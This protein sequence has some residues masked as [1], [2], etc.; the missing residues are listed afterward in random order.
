MNTARVSRNIGAVHS[1]GAVSASR[2]LPVA[3][4]LRPGVKV[5][6][7]AAAGNPA[8]VAIYQEGVASGASFDDIAAAMSKV[9]GAPNYPLTPRNV[10]WFTARQGDFATPGAAAKILDLY[11][12]V[13]H[14]D[15]ERHIYT[16][17]II[18]PADDMDLVF[19]EQFEAWR[20]SELHRWSEADPETGVLQCMKRVE[21]TPDKSARRRWGGR[22]TEAERPCDPNDCALFGSGECKHIGSLSFWVPGVTGTSVIDLTFTSIYAS[23]GIAETLDMVRAGLG[24]ISGLHNGRPIFWLSK[25]REQVSQMNWETGKP[26][27]TDQWIIRLEASGLD[28]V[29]VLTGT[30]QQAALPAP[31]TAKVPALEEPEPPISADP[32]PEPIPQATT[33]TDPAIRELR[34]QLAALRDTLGWEDADLKE[35]VDGQGYDC[36]V[37]TR[38]AGCLVDMVAKLNLAIEAKSQREA[39]APAAEPA[40]ALALVADTEAP[41]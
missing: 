2:R 20:A 34:V 40:E 29:E 10:P 1:S 25:G 16:L 33:T 41:F 9:K 5:L 17:P 23:M 11:G 19:R 24:R 3:G 21:V 13:R 6:T 18:F 12:E 27:K 31:E 15:P 14:G 28:M 37:P 38:D 35:W 36:E 39:S 22:P 26:Q 8:L 32:V 7:K 30:G 4:K